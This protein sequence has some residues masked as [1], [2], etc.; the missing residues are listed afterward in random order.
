MGPLEAIDRA[1]TG[2]VQIVEF[3]PRV[4][5][6]AGDYVLELI[7]RIFTA[8]WQFLKRAVKIA[9]QFVRDLIVSLF[10]VAINLFLLASIFLVFIFMWAFGSELQSA[11]HTLSGW[12]LKGIG[13]AGTLFVVAAIL[14]SFVRP[15]AQVGSGNSRHGMYSFVVVLNLTAALFVIYFG[16]A[17]TYLFNNSFLY[18]TQLVGSRILYAATSSAPGDSS[19][20]NLREQASAFLD[21]PE[22]PASALANINGNGRFADSHMVGSITNGTAWTI[23]RMTHVFRAPRN[24]SLPLV[25][26]RT[27][28]TDVR[29]RPLET[30]E[31]QCEFPGL[32]VTQDWRWAVT[33]AW[34]LPRQ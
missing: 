9:Y 30:K 11:G 21:P 12:T 17:N 34:G 19:L 33:H 26:E 29:L 10:K 18:Y 25:W 5:G 4:L 7:S 31:F 2:L 23:L 8:I 6:R 13:A 16:Y 20:A 3:F 14:A 1:L 32:Q 15:S 22:M 24:P 28:D 27:C